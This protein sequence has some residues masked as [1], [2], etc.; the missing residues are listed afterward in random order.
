MF[1]STQNLQK[2]SFARALL[3]IFILYYYLSIYHR[4]TY[5]QFNI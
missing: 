1:K 2:P 5:V 3:P 4:T